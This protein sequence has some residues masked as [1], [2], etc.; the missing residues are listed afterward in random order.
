MDEWERK[1][2]AVCRSKWYAGEGLKKLGESYERHASLH[3]CEECQ[4]FWEQFVR[5]VDTITEAQAST[6]YGKET[7]SSRIELQPNFEPRNSLETLLVSLQIAG[8]PFR[9]FLEQLLNSDVFVLSNDNPSSHSFNPIQYVRSGASYVATFTSLERTQRLAKQFPNCL[10]I[11][12]SEL[13]R[14]ISPSVGLVLNPGW[15]VGFEI[16]ASGLE[17]IRRDFLH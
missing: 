2:C 17:G 6:I 9:E 5:Y 8:I 3:Y 7:V 11:R 1:G 14:R 4:T 10:S 16:P 15:T 12:A 13:L